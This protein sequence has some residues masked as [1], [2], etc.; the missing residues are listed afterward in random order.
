[1][2]A[3][4]LCGLSY[5]A[6]MLVYDGSPF[7][8]DPTVLLRLAS[9]LKYV[10]NQLRSLTYY[11]RGC[12]YVCADLFARRVSVFGTSARYLTD[13]MTLGVKPRKET[14]PQNVCICLWRF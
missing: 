4:A 3:L 5:G 6:K 1:M 9:Q 8:P 11:R 13:L 10:Q 14:S 7:K 12:S 2:W